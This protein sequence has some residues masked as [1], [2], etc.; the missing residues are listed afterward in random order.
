MSEDKKEK[1]YKWR[2]ENYKENTQGLLMVNTGDG[3]GKTTAALGVL[4]RAA[5]R[6]MNCCFDPIYEI[7]NRP[8]RRTRIFGRTR[9]RSLHDGRR[10]H[11]GH[12]RQSAG[13]Q[14]ERRNLGVMRRKNAERRLRS[15][16]F[17]RTRLCS[18]LRFFEFG[19]SHRRNQK[20]A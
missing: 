13:H 20:C 14:N 5:G 18:R 1:R 8:L 9:H 17:R 3:K 12:E 10:F 7:E 15:F 4:V 2:R 19:K 16:S 11:L 6:G